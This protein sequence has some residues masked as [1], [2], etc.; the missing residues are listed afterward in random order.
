MLNFSV[1]YLR[2]N[3]SSLIFFLIITIINYSILLYIPL[4]NSSIIDDIANRIFNSNLTKS[5]FII[6]ILS[7]LNIILSYYLGLINIKVSSKISYE[8]NKDVLFHIEK[9]SIFFFYKNSAA[10]I[11]QRINSDSN[12]ISN[13][14]ITGLRD[15]IINIA[16][17]IVSFIILCNI[18]SKIAF[19]L[20]ILVPV[21]AI[22]YFV[23]R[24]RIYK[25]N[26]EFKETQNLFFS[27]MNMHLD[28]IKI[29]KIN[30]LFNILKE[31]LNNAFSRLFERA[32]ILTKTTSLFSGINS[33]ITI[34]SN[35]LI[36]YF[37][38]MEIKSN[39]LSLGEFTILTLYF[40]NM[41]NS[42]KYFLSLSSEFQ[43]I[44][45]SYDRLSEWI[46]MKLE[47]NNSLM[48]KSI[49]DIKVEDLSFGYTESNLIYDS[50]RF[51]FSKGNIYKVKGKNGSGKSSLVN[52]LIGLYNNHFTGD[53]KIN[54]ISIKNLD[55]Y[56]VRNK[57][58]GVTEQEPLLL[59][60]SIMNNI[61]YN[62]DEINTNKLNEYI[63]LLNMT[64]FLSKLPN[65][66]DTVL[67]PKSYNLSGGE[68]QK[69]SLLRTLLK[70][71]DVLIFDEATSALDKQTTNNLKL[72][73]ESI[74]R[75][76][77]IIVIDHNDNFDDIVDNVLEIDL[78]HDNYLIE[79]L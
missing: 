21:Y 71:P 69:I 10:Y 32:M 42:L 28:N 23:F 57:L 77:I 16:M 72:L 49:D 76:K 4:I 73:I 29:V 78:L 18:N 5:I 50:F 59:P 68:K 56:N 39:N 67:S 7:L 61:T 22:I 74:K 9:V 43:N 11:N 25:V 45:A 70:D 51:T 75:E 35:T 12:V 24:K 36:L 26:Y 47:N 38:I 48:I 60:D 30:V 27:E 8:I 20:I 40:S 58:I 64:E 52:L 31:R 19:I 14:I 33:L 53:V 34:T 63:E 62:L 55:M 1:K 6:F 65:Y 15:I 2:K 54:G 66:L 17:F 13:F 79:S 46:S 3:L 41:M 44:K 37:G